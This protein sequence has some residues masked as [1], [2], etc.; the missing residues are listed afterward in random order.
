MFS[1]VLKV[2]FCVESK[3]T[4]TTKGQITGQR[5]TF[6]F[7]GLWYCGVR[8]VSTHSGGAHG[9]VRSDG[10]VK[11]A[12]ACLSPWTGGVVGET[13]TSQRRF[14]TY[15]LICFPRRWLWNFLHH[16]ASPQKHQPQTTLDLLAARPGTVDCSSVNT[17]CV[18]KYFC[19]HQRTAP[20]YPRSS[21]IHFCHSHAQTL[22]VLLFAGM[23]RAVLAV[24]FLNRDAFV[25]AGS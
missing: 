5:F 22:F 1:Q 9:C 23:R 8:H 2:L 18:C 17:I 20:C 15:S 24:L 16:V 21:C 3:K 13:A 6:F 19:W 10:R 12:F 7:L 14:T 4:T 25:P 11:I